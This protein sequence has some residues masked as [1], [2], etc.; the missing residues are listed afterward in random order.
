MEQSEPDFGANAKENKQS[1]MVKEEPFVYLPTD[2]PELNHI[3]EFFGLSPSFPTTDLFVRNAIGE[4]LRA[5]YISNAL[6]RG[7]LNRNPTIRLLNAG[8]RLFVRQ[9]DPKS[10]STCLWRVHS[11]G[12][13]L[14]D[15][16]LGSQRVVKAG[17]D[18]IWELLK[19]GSQ[20][21]LISSL[22]QGIRDQIFN[23]PNGGFVIRVDPSKSEL[24]DLTVPFSM[25]MWKSPMAVKYIFFVEGPLLTV[26]L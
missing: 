5:I 11:D 14:V 20:F 24:T 25:P 26:V 22:K 10:E 2:H 21:P 8:T 17:V 4:P 1:N 19:S 23:L 6:V 16:F 18:E 13:E 7:V 15:P 12:L 3:R 9:A